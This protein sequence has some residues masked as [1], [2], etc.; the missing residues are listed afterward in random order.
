M[1]DLAEKFNKDFKRDYTLRARMKLAACLEADRVLPV[2][3]QSRLDLTSL[4][5][6]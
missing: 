1:N 4:P 6:P 2:Q 5:A 3:V